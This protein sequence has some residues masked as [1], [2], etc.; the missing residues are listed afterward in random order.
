MEGPLAPS[1]GPGRPL[2]G[3]RICGPRPRRWERPRVRRLRRR[4]TVV[5]VRRAACVA[6]IG[7]GSCATSTRRG[8][9]PRVPPRGPPRAFGTA[10]RPVPSSSPRRRTGPDPVARRPLRLAVRMRACLPGDDAGRPAPRGPGDDPARVSGVA[11]RRYGRPVVPP[12]G[13]AHVEACDGGDPTMAHGVEEGRGA[14]VGDERKTAG[15]QPAACPRD[16]APSE[17]EERPV[18]SSPRQR[19][20]RMER[21]PGGAAARARPPRGGAARP[22]RPAHRGP[23][24]STRRARDERMG[25]RRMRPARMRRIRAARSRP[26]RP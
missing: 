15:R 7:G 20:S 25:A 5:S 10:L 6:C 22:M 23:L 12:Y 17:V 9:G 4:R 13:G 8:D 3:S 26:G 24:V 14:A 16:H 21:S 18:P 2:P 19:G 11:D 1:A